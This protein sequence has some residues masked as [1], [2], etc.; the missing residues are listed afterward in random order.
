[1][2]QVSSVDTKH[3]TQLKEIKVIYSQAKLNEHG[4]ET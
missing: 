4:P 2:A 1:M 3:S